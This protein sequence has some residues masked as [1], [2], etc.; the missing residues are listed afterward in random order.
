[1]FGVRQGI[2]L[3]SIFLRKEVEMVGGKGFIHG[4]HLQARKLLSVITF[5]IMIFSRLI[6]KFIGWGTCWETWGLRTLGWVTGKFE[7]ILFKE[8]S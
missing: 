1:M 5:M 4:R 8:D 6:G 7:R 3:P 2:R